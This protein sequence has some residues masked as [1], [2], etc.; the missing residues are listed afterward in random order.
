MTAPTGTSGPGRRRATKPV[1]PAG[2][3]VTR[4]PRPSFQARGWRITGA[5]A[6]AALLV[7]WFTWYAMTPEELSTTESTISATGVVG[8]PVYFGMY[9][10]GKSFDRTLRVNGVKVRATTSADLTITP[11]LC[12]RG[13]VGV[14]TR[15][16]QF[17]AELIDP[18]GERLTGDD[19]I[20]LKVEAD[21]P[22]TAVV[23]QIEIAYREDLRWD[24]QPAGAG[25]AIVSITGRPTSE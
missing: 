23:N 15:P 24:T 8:A 10:P 2:L 9:A 7:G 18:E 11:L 12:R 21:Q 14:T 1:R 25:Q 5:V 6:T 22:V 19:S 16:E 13:T 20:V 4:V 17:C 3:G